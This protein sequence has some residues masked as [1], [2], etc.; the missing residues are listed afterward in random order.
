MAASTMRRPAGRAAAFGRPAVTGRRG[1][2]KAVRAAS[3]SPCTSSCAPT[4]WRS[5]CCARLVALVGATV[6]AQSV[7]ALPVGPRVSTG[8][9]RVASAPC[10]PGRVAL[11]PAVVRV[12]RLLQGQLNEPVSPVLAVEV[13]AGRDDVFELC[14]WDRQAGDNV[15]NPA[16]FLGKIPH[17][18]AAGGLLRV[19]LAVLSVDRDAW[20]EEGHAV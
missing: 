3:P 5:E 2:G 1:S 12:L 7:F 8:A 9:E 18:L 11:P 14:R 20:P 16:C 10:E 15:A 19:A 6:S 13:A 17:E 4:R